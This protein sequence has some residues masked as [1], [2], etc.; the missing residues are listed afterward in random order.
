MWLY[1]L[2]QQIPLALVILSHSSEGRGPVVGPGALK[3]SVGEGKVSSRLLVHS[4]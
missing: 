2:Y 4:H 1:F 3:P